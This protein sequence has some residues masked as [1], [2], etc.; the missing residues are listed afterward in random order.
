M[1]PSM[2]QRAAW[3]SSMVTMASRSEVC[4]HCPLPERSRSMRAQR[5][6]WARKM[7]AVR[8]ATGMP[9]RT[10]P[11]PGK[12]VTD[13][14]P[15]MPGAVAIRPGLS[16]AGDAAVD[17]ARVDPGQRFVV[18]AEPVLHVRTEVLHHHVGL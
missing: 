18:D 12:P 11:C 16:E 8:S 10:G 17:D 6:P 4:T 5:M 7:P 9:T 13:M 14:S 2:S 3:K 15:P 1:A